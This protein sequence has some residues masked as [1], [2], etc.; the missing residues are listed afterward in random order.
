[1][2]SSE[3]RGRLGDEA[4]FELSLAALSQ[5]RRNRPRGI[6]IAAIGAVA[7]AVLFAG[8]GVRARSSARAELRR[9]LTDQVLVERL[10]GEWAALEAQE[11]DPRAGGGGGRQPIPNLLTR[12]EDLAVQAG[13]ERPRQPRVGTPE[14][15][16]GVRVTQY[17][18][19]EGSNPITHASL[20][21]LLEWL[22]LAEGEELG[23]EVVGLSLKPD[24]NN[25]KMTVTF[26]RWE[27]AG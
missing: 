19:G 21:T 5:E 20:E 22:R 3:D 14:V 6:V 4:R 9:T 2:S 13:L 23:M 24:A 16:G 26:R 1:M 18:Y 11:R 15:R 12:M 8:Y 10:S 27:R 17:H 25:W 7:L